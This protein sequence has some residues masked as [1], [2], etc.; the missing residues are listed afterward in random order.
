MLLPNCEERK[1]IETNFSAKWIPKNV[2][3]L[4]FG[5]KYD[6]ICP[7]SLFENDK[8]FKRDNIELIYVENAGH[9]ILIENP[10]IMINTFRDYVAKFEKCG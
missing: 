8:R 6:C 1:A 3:T 4:I 9:F 5:S 2:P 10:Q 7:F